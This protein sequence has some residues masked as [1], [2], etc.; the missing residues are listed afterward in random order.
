MTVSRHH[1]QTRP[2][3]IHKID[4]PYTDNTFLK[5]NNLFID[6]Y[7]YPYVMFVFEM[8]DIC[9]KK[10]N[11]SNFAFYLR[12]CPWKPLHTESRVTLS[13]LAGLTRPVSSVVMVTVSEYA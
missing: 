7:V 10:E 11:K 9:N 12:Q 13:V 5:D 2:H 3:H 1:K 8:I 6:N 4:T